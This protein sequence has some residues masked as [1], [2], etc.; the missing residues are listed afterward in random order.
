MWRFKFV[1]VGSALNDALD[2]NADK[3]PAKSR[4]FGHCLIWGQCSIL[5]ICDHFPCPKVIFHSTVLDQ[6]DW[7]NREFQTIWSWSNPWSSD[8]PPGAPWGL[9]SGEE[10]TSS[11]KSTLNSVGDAIDSFDKARGM[12]ADD[13]AMAA[14]ATA[15]ETTIFLTAKQKECPL[16]PACWAHLWIDNDRYGMIWVSP[17]TL[18]FTRCHSD[19]GRWI[20][21]DKNPERFRV[22]RFV[23][24]GDFLVWKWMGATPKNMGIP[25]SMVYPQRV[26]PMWKWMGATPMSGN[27]KVRN[28]GWW[29]TRGFYGFQIFRQKPNVEG[30]WNS[31][32]TLWLLLVLTLQFSNR[33]FHPQIRWT[34]RFASTRFEYVLISITDLIYIYIY[35][36]IYMH[37]I[38]YLYIQCNLW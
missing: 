25:P 14:M 9:P 33:T 16:V 36:K 4:L 10:S 23:Q 34:T 18:V 37:D 3:D 15:L 29:W 30:I 32:S 17:R 6:L 31:A 20:R 8:E 26:H 22:V 1:Q 13:P 19:M 35:I 5:W 7:W 11:V 2:S 21:F 38:Q 12:I 27:L 28:L 24:S